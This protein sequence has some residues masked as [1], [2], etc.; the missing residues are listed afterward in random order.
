MLY[1]ICGRDMSID[2]LANDMWAMGVV[3]VFL[4]GGYNIFGINY[5]DCA[6]VELKPDE[7]YS[8]QLN[9][10]IGKQSDWVSSLLVLKALM[11]IADTQFMWYQI[12]ALPCLPCFCVC[13]ATALVF[14]TT[15]GIGL[16]HSPTIVQSTLRISLSEML[17]LCSAKGTQIQPQTLAHTQNCCRCFL[18]RILPQHGTLCVN[19][20]IQNRAKGGLYSR[21]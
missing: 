11:L 7:L 15:S 3:L 12:L 14:V 1:Q 10:L 5:E 9:V 20:C 2:Q 13:L 17:W 8:R 4:L 21:L 16:W 6:D 19:C 18:G